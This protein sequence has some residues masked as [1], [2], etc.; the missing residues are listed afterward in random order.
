MFSIGHSKR[1]HSKHALSKLHGSKVP[2]PPFHHRASSFSQSRTSAPIKPVASDLLS[3][4]SNTQPSRKASYGAFVG[5]IF[6]AL[7]LAL[8]FGRLLVSFIR[9]K[10]STSHSKPQ[11]GNTEPTDYF[12]SAP[13]ALENETYEM[14]PPKAVTKCDS[15]PGIKSL[16]LSR[17]S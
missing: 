16:N 1:Y 4:Q 5:G 12:I 2:N 10:Y 14:A 6:G 8:V 13:A 7:I 17:V 11:P 15:S 9:G 3:A